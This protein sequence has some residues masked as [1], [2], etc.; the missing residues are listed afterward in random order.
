MFQAKYFNE[1][2]NKELYEILKSRI[3][4]FTVEQNIIYQDMDNIDYDSLH[5]FFMEEE[6]VSAYLRVFYLDEEK[7]IVKI[8]RVLTLK[9]G[10]G[11]GR[12]LLE[13]SLPVIKNKMKCKKICLDAQKYAVGFYE[14]FGFKVTSGDFLEEGIIHNKMELEIED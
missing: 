2:T 6:R 13:K 3:D 10:C 7:K 8:G 4:I 11:K 9:H 1:L 14:K 5:L 12:E